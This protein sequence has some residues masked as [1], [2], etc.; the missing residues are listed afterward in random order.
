[1][2]VG[3]RDET[4]PLRG[5]SHVIEH[6][7][8]KGTATRSAQQIAD[9]IDMLGGYLNAFTDKEYTCYYAKV[10]DEHTAVAIDVIS[11]MFLNS[12]IDP[13]ELSREQNVILEEIKRHEDQPDDLIHDVFFQTIW[14]DHVLG[15]SVIGTAETVSSFKPQDLFDY[16]GTRYTPD[17]I[18]VSAAGRLDHKRVVEMIQERFGHLGG[19]RDLWRVPDAA[20]RPVSTQTFVPKPVEQMHVLLGVPAYSQL[21]DRRFA[22]GLLDTAVGGG[23]SS[24]LFQEIREKRGLAYSVGSYSSSYREG[25]LF[26]V[27]AGTSTDTA[28]E[29]IDITRREFVNVRDNNISADELLRAK[30]QI[31]GSLVMSQESMS[32]R[33][34]RMG[35][36]EL[37]HDRVVPI[38]ELIDK[39]QAINLDDIKA[40]ACDLLAD[41][42]EV[43]VKIGPEPGTEPVAVWEDSDDDE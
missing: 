32:S 42:K 16:M 4:D 23:M 31:K 26:A 12:V 24:R 40:T 39:I 2:G 18:V 25:G 19:T 1:V 10:L 8:F 14:P 3:A 29:V 9:Q 30:N 34:M 5:I 37:V 17:T 7:L 22:L 11:D 21:D 35:K 15:K 33:M 28:D 36:S 20:P 13:A 27:Y 38:E 6:M 41:G 43:L